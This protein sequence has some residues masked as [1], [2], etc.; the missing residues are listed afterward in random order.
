VIR[1]KFYAKQVGEIVSGVV[2]AAT[3]QQVTLGLDMKAEG[4]LPRNQQINGEHF[5]V[6]DRVQ[7]LL[8]EVKQTPRGPQIILS[9]S[10]RNFLRCLLENEVPE[11][12][13]GLVEIRSIARE[14][15]QRSKVAVAALQPAVDPVGACVGIRGVRIQ[16]IVRE[17][18]DEKIDVIEYDSDPSAYIAKALSPARV[19]GVYLNEHAK[20]TKTATVVVMEDQLSLAIGRDGQN[21]RL[22]AKLTG[23]RIDIK[24]LLEAAG[25][26]I[27]RLQSDAEFAS[28]AEIEAENTT[29][30]EIIL[31]KKSEGR[32]I[33]PEEYQF[34]S[35]FADRGAWFIHR[36]IRKTG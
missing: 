35:Q 22:A 1:K 7:S 30:V 14:P 31:G 5:R 32:P 11:I 34:M 13:H 36:R 4:V 20:G 25:D 18:N 10:H 17:L 29:R 26:A 12:Y 21:A 19:N 8:L 33:T 2:Q 9:R 3:P 16:A 24:S 6:H 27:H 15:G 28:M 23:W